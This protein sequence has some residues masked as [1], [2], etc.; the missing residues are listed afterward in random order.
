MSGYVQDAAGAA[1]PD[2]EERP[3]M[4]NANNLEEYKLLIDLY[5]Y[6]TQL[7]FDVLKY[8]MGANLALVGTLVFGKSSELS[9]LVGVV[10]CL[11][12]ISVSVAA[13]VQFRKC[14]F[15]CRAFRDRALVIE[16]ASGAAIF[17]RIKKLNLK[18]KGT[19]WTART[20]SLI[21]ISMIVLLWLLTLLN[22]LGISYI[23][24]K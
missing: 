13:L 19:P 5:K 24:V 11:L 14:I 12:A 7:S 18:N 3:L 21:I 22:A 9:G 8:F 20:M 4:A 16:G 17:A 2:D 15:H 1:A 10:V 6:Y 23:R